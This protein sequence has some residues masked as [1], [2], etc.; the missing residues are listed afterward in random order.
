MIEPG[1]Y[2][3]IHSKH[4]SGFFENFIKF[5]KLVENQFSTKIKVFQTDGGGEFQSYK[6]IR[7]LEQSEFKVTS[8]VRA[9]RNKMELQQGSIDTSLRPS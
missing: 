2:G 1:S 8:Y 9:L 4:K 6:F 3:F 5:E 7:Y